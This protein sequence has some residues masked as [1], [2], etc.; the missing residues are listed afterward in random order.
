LAP[1]FGISAGLTNLS[2][3]HGQPGPGQSRV[4][5]GA[6]DV[7]FED[8]PCQLSGFAGYLAVAP[9]CSVMTNTSFGCEGTV[10]LAPRATWPRETFPG[11][12]QVTS[13][14]LW[15]DGTFQFS[16]PID[17]S[18]PDL[19]YIAGRGV[20]RASGPLQPPLWIERA[21]SWHVVRWPRVFMGFVIERST[22]GPPPWA[23]SAAFPG[24]EFDDPWLHFA[25]F[26]PEEFP[27]VFYRLREQAPGL[28]AA[29]H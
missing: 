5:V 8:V 11:F 4:V 27:A 17:E 24:L 26:E 2:I 25:V 13:N 3:R 18:E 16:V 19:G 28:G 20:V 29:S 9:G 1:G 23:W 14:R 21:E 15:F 22:G 10:D 6:G 7:V 12:L